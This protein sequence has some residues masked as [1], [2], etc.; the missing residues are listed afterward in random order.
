MKI[1]NL[2]KAAFIS[3]AKNKM[4]SLLTML[5]IIIGVGAVMVM[6]AIGQG[7]Q[8]QIENQINSLGTNLIIIFPGSAN[9]SGVSQGAGTF[10]RLTLDDVSLIQK[11][12]YNITGVSPI[13]R[14]GGQL[15]GGVGNWFS[16]VYGVS[17]DYFTIRDWKLEYGDPFTET[18]VR[19]RNKVCVLGA[20]IA[21]NLFP[22]EDPVGQQLRIRNVP[23]RIIGVLSVKGQNADGQDQDDCV[24]APYTTV[25]YR[26]SGWRFITQILCSAISPEMI[27]ATEKELE[28]LMREA[29]KIPNGMP[30]DFTIMNQTDIAKAAQTTTQVLTTLLASIAGISL[31]VGGIGIMNIMLVSV[32]ER[33]REIGIRMAIGARGGD[34]LTQFLV[35]AILLSL[36]GGIIGMLLGVVATKIVSNIYGWYT[37]LS[38]ITMIIS[39]GFSGLVGIF[40]GFYPARKASAL[41]P[42]DALHFE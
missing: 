16:S 29:H 42:I 17:P 18:D 24:L 32:T 10:S 34:I 23:F 35:E 8:S 33:T 7:A 28:E 25:Q 26:L 14:T 38:P 20:T 2:F 6:V 9:T 19:T 5:G 3:I 22:N 30:D 13:I 36:G 37:T 27:P 4:R 31:I 1:R 40:F 21:K 39:F 15:I 12:A 11:N 41:N